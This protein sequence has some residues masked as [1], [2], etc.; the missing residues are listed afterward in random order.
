MLQAVS[1]VV[2]SAYL[3]FIGR[4]ALRQA[5]LASWPIAF[6]PILLALQQ[7][8]ESVMWLP[9]HV[10]IGSIAMTHFVLLTFFLWPIW[11][12]FS[13][14]CIESRRDR[15]LLIVCTWIGLLGAAWLLYKSV[16]LTYDVYRPL[17]QG[18]WDWGMQ[19]YMA[20]IIIPF[21]FSSNPGIVVLGLM[22]VVSGIISCLGW[23]LAFLS[24]SN[25]FLEV[26]SFVWR[27][28]AMGI[29]SAL[30]VYL[31]YWRDNKHGRPKV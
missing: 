4:L 9:E 2:A 18:R 30:V 24:M 11:I 15:R 10:L 3:F 31:P 14:F 13:L 22:F 28:L 6:I 5:K 25:D 19:L 7:A 1:S 17:V 12:P 20:S 27:L 29:S 23:Q 16:F 21:T 8:F 26:L